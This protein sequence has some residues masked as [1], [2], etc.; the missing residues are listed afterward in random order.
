MVIIAKIDN[1]EKVC[2]DFFFLIKF[3]TIDG[4]VAQQ[5]N[6]TATQTI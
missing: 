1:E 6:V 5:M 3:E 2:Q 4:E